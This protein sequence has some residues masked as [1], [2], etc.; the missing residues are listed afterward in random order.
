VIV[1]VGYAEL[2]PPPDL[3]PWVACFWTRLSPILAAETMHRVLPD[4]CV[5]IIFGFGHDEGTPGTLSAI[6]VGPMTKPIFVRGPE[7][8]LR[9]GVRFRPGRAFA[10][11]GIPAGSIVDENVPFDAL[12]R[13]ASEELEAIAGHTS[14]DGRLGAVVEL[15]RRRLRSAP[16]V[17]GAMRAAVSRIVE[18]RGNLRIAS[19]ASD[20]GVTRQQLARQFAI[21][22]GI[23]PKMLARVMRAHAVL[24]RV[25]AARAAYPRAVDWTA[26][27]C[28]LGYYDQPHFI[29]DFK[30]LTGSTP[31]AYG[32]L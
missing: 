13:G 25:D 29:D 12:S 20:I 9:I 11:L 27:A 19:I 8:L 22:V 17:P 4:G 26:I 7:P 2:P 3:V 31:A 10:A 32:P 28:E 14:N 16:A 30:A 5:D 6:G 18:A 23:T 15:V 21:H 24:A 1:P